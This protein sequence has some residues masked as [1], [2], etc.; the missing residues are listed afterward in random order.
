MNKLKT[1]LIGL[2]KQK[3]KENLP[4]LRKAN[5]Y[6]VAGGHDINVSLGRIIED[7]EN[8]PWGLW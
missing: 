7:R 8:I 2:G 4:A 1:V 5:K 6:E 3:L